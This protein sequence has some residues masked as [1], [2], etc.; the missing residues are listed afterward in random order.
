M[1]SLK[2]K[3]WEFMI[4]MKRKP[5]VFFVFRH[6]PQDEMK[7]KNKQPIKSKCWIVKR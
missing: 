1:S 2:L 6:Y 5:W 7:E 4:E 3:S